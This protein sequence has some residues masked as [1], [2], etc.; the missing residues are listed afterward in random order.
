MALKAVIKQLCQP[1][2]SLT[3]W[4]IQLI[5]PLHVVY[6]VNNLVDTQVLKAIF[7]HK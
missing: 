3:K 4:K 7:V 5:S 2:V 1:L 6:D